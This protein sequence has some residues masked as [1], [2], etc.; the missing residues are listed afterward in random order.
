LFQKIN[1][2]LS[3]QTIKKNYFYMEEK[4]MLRLLKTFLVCVG[5]IAVIIPLEG[6]TGFSSTIENSTVDV[7]KENECDQNCCPG[8]RGRKGKRG[9]RGRSGPQGAMGTGGTVGATG[10]TGPTGPTGATG[11]SFDRVRAYASVTEMTIVLINPG[12]PF[13]FNSGV[14]NLNVDVS[15]ITTGQITILVSGDY[16]V[17]YSI[18]P[19]N[20]GTYAINLEL[21]GA[22]LFTSQVGEDLTGF[23]QAIVGMHGDTIQTFM[24]GDVLEL[25]NSGASA[26]FPSQGY[27]VL[28]KLN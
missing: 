14:P 3:I 13:Q 20:P 9:K 1:I 24:A 27:I 11:D 23:A 2:W 18:T 28:E 6:R 7:K 8:E 21:N 17:S 10:P 26:I 5:F 16:K 22:P 15:A 12:A 25:V 4:F 19:N